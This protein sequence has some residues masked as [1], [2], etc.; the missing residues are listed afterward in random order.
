MCWQELLYLDTGLNM[1]SLVSK[2]NIHHSKKGHYVGHLWLN[3]GRWY[4]YKFIIKNREYMFLMWPDEFV[5]AELFLHGNI[6]F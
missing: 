5:V 3:V 1:K 6:A 4:A 2:Q